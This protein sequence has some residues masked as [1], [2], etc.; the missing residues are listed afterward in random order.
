VTTDEVGDAPR[1]APSST[2]D[3]LVR[4]AA[5]LLG[6]TGAVLHGVLRLSYVFF[7]MKLRTTP[8]EVGYGYV[9]IL[10]T[11]LIGAIEL[12]LMVAALIL[13]VVVSTRYLSVLLRSTRHRA[14]PCPA[15]W[16][17]RRSSCGGSAAS[18][19]CWQCSS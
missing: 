15:A 8:E 12:V 19:S 6:L 14:D 16:G 4:V 17:P 11:Q 5:P 1:G 13:A 3:W 18:P 10:A 7:Y 2:L 9:E